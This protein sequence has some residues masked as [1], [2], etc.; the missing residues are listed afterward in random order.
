MC[1]PIT[2]IPIGGIK[3]IT[4]TDNRWLRCNIK[5]IT[6]LANVL[7]RQDAID[8]GASE[9]ILIR[10]EKVIEGAAS[11]IFLVLENTLVTP[12]LGAELLPGITRDLVLEL[13][14]TKGV[15][16]SERAVR[17]EEL[18]SAQEIWMTSSTREILPVVEL[19][20]SPVGSGVPGPVWALLQ[21]AYQDY[22]AAIRSS[23]T[24]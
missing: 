15:P 9:A 23:I 18:A 10:D 4:V 19:N 2:S 1:T 13:A 6:L 12:P 22:K 20:G 5:A 3:A 14:K 17:V 7:L 24:T 11:N 16:T 8:Q 21:E